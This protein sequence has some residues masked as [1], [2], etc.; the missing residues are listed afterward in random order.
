[1]ERKRRRRGRKRERK[2]SSLR[3]GRE[4]HNPYLEA[5]EAELQGQPRWHGELKACLE[6]IA[7]LYVREKKKK[8][9]ITKPHI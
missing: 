8:K 6:W 7:R 9:K 1:M 2:G 4:M 3:P 5:G